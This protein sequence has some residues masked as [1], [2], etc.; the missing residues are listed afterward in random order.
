VTGGAIADVEALNKA[1]IAISMGSGCSAAKEM[2]DIVL[3]EDDF[4]ATLKAMMWG[5]NIY[6]NVSRF[7]QF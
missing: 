2:S 3:T 6:H 4:E 1:D 5:R 7:L